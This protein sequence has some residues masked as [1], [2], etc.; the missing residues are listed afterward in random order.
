M[1]A[2]NPRAAGAPQRSRPGFVSTRLCR[3]PAPSEVA[4]QTAHGR[5][6]PRNPMYHSAH[7]AVPPGAIQATPPTSSITSS[8]RRSRFVQQRGKQR[9]RVKPR[10]I[11]DR[12]AGRAAYL[13]FLLGCI[14][15]TERSK[16]TF[17]NYLF[18]PSILQTIPTFLA[19]H[20]LR[21]M[22]DAL[23]FGATHM[24]LGILANVVQ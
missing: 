15:I 14:C 22:N 9:A 12:S 6:Q 24:E 17:H 4:R 13:A 11:P 7:G 8:A 5:L 23:A 20:R 16:S 1:S 21:Y 18:L 10:H 2:R 19:Y 3:L